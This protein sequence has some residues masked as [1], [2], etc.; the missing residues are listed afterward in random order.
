MGEDLGEDLRQAATALTGD[1]LDCRRVEVERPGR[2]ILHLMRED[3]EA[4]IAIE[5]ASDDPPEGPSLGMGNRRLVLLGPEMFAPDAQALLRQVRET[6]G[7]VLDGGL[8]FWLDPV[9]SP[10]EDETAAILARRD[11]TTSLLGDCNRGGFESTTE[12]KSR[13]FDTWGAGDALGTSAGIEVREELVL[14]MHAS[15]ECAFATNSLSGDISAG[16]RPWGREKLDL[17][18]APGNFLVTDVDDRSIIKGGEERFE[19]ALQDALA[20]HPNA[21]VSVF[22]G[23]DYHMIGDNI[24]PVCRACAG[25]D[26]DRIQFTQPQIPQFQEMN[27]RSWWGSFL[28]ACGSAG[29]PRA[30]IPTVNLAGYGPPGSADVLEMTALLSAAGVSVAAVA[31]PFHSDHAAERW[32]EAWTTLV[33]PW[34]PV[35]EMFTDQIRRL[36]LPY[37]APALPYGVQ[38]TRVWLAGVC[39]VLGLPA[40]DPTW[41]D[42]TF[43]ARASR[44]PELMRAT[45]GLR[46]GVVFDKGSLQELISP[47]FFYGTTP[48]DALGD[49]DFDLTIV[50]APRTP[51]PEPT[52]SGALARL[53][54]RDVTFETWDPSVPLDDVL[55]HYDFDL[56]YCDALD[57]GFLRRAGVTPFTMH[58][59]G[60]GPGGAVRSLDNL[61]A[62]G[63]LRLYRRYHRFLEAGP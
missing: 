37:A 22:Q 16:M 43:A 56:V 51:P 41:F 54:R 28:D 35:D 62:R 52:R 23:C 45:A 10:P 15:R 20:A 50:H 34:L 61:L 40:P 57:T 7:P 55:A 2:L 27:S 1:G 19:A 26:G 18:R 25:V 36:G 24:H 8:A 44:L 3:V 58:D 14:L 29:T 30:D 47:V 11:Q 59:L 4:R 60:M 21:H 31:M 32:G 53:H 9:S 12:R 17:S 5:D 63:R 13:F 42:A 6:S 48:L 33:S 46:C 49:A 38:G 39:D